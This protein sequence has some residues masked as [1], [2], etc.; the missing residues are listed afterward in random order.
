[1]APSLPLTEVDR[2]RF[3]NYSIVNEMTAVFAQVA[4]W[5]SNRNPNLT[6]KDYLINGKGIP[7]ETV[8]KLFKTADE[9][10]KIELTSYE[11]L[12]ITFMHKLLPHIC[13]GI[14]GSGGGPAVGDSKSLEYHLREIKN[15]R[16]SV[17][18][19]PHGTALDKNLVDKVEKIALKLLDIAGV[20][21]GK[22]TDEINAAKDEA[23][24]LI[25]TIRNTDFTEEGKIHFYQQRLIYE[26]LPK[27]REKT[28][29]YKG[30][31]S[32]YFEHVNR[33]CS[34][35]LMYKEK[36]ADKIISCEEILTQAKEK[37]ERILII[38][39]QSGSGKSYLMKEL[40]ADILRETGK[41]FQ[42]S[43]EFDTPLLF[44]CRKR[45]CETIA[46]FATEEFPCL[47]ATST[48][49][50]LTEKILGGMKS[51]LLV[52][53]VDEANEVS[54]K[55]LDNIIAYLKNNRDLLCIFTSRPFSAEEF[56]TKLKRQGF[57]DFQTLALEEL[58][59]EEEQR[60][61]L[62]SLCKKGEDI[63][64][65]YEDTNL[66][67][68]SPVLLAIFS[69]LWLKNPESLKSCKSEKQI[70]RAWIDSGLEVAKQR[71]EQ[72]N[73]IDFED[74]AKNIL[75]SISLV[76][77]SCLL[78]EQLEIKAN[79]IKWL[80]RE[81]KKEFTGI[82]V[83]MAPHEIISCFFVDSSDSKNSLLLFAH[84]SQQ[85]LLSSLYVAEHIKR[86][87]YFRQI[88]SEAL[89]YDDPSQSPMPSAAN[90]DF[91]LFLNKWVLLLL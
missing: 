23:K 63:S 1:M 91:R 83:N 79:E 17:M 42:G 27:L 26:G 78:K 80:K 44:E 67:L 73:V 33:F 4:E 6:F 68:E 41:I 75:E 47:G 31:I 32:P 7:P 90:Y 71:L 76:S 86:G 24:K 13:D 51:L 69:Y 70:M 11:T 38:E 49:E 20:K 3:V 10:K 5:G 74:I 72:R 15:I 28:E 50:G 87:K 36:D 54:N 30:C 64:S 40:Q 53:G 9:K 46:K 39:G 89:E 62:K 8:K 61:F 2:T 16:N 60:K 59:S 19:E 34:L 85:E 18:H 29:Y 66:D 58:I 82:S 84:K 55:M 22:V 21:Y 37:G 14:D 12:D 88:L 25:S 65:A 43:D 56:R 48:E 81:I 45:T 52:D 77:F 35:Q 57:S